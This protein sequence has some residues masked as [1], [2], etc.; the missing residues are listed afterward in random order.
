MDLP[1]YAVA[2]AQRVID[3]QLTV[4][5]PAKFVLI[6]HNF[7]LANGNRATTPW[8][9][10]D[11]T[12]AESVWQ[13]L[14]RPN[15]SVSFVLSGHYSAERVRSDVNACGQPIH[16]ILADFQ[17]RTNGG[18]GWL[19]YVTFRPA[20]D[21]VDVFTYSPTLGRSEMEANSRFTLAFPM[22]G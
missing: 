3:S 21:A 15:C 8:W 14:V 9:R 17:R 7:L 2:W 10:P 5:Q 1:G 12:S 4:D 6:T 19:R 20:D 18:D 22:P 11:G 16:Q 13:T